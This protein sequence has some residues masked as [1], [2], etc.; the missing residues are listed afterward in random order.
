[1]RFWAV[2]DRTIGILAFLSGVLIIFAMLVVCTDVSSRFFWNYPIMW[3]P[4]I[5][6]LSLLFIAFLGTAWLLK[7]EGHVRVDIILARVSPRTQALLGIF[8]SIIGIFTCLF[9]VW[10]GI[11]VSWQ[12]TAEGI[13]DPTILE[14]PKGPIST[15]IPIGSFLLF[16]QFLRGTYSYWRKWQVS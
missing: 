14:L 16:I 5:T 8:A 15:I 7:E 9:L 11:Q 6:A 13:A 2:F 1:V 10:Y 3:V 12:F 4:E